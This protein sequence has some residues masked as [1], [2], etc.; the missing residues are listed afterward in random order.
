MICIDT[1]IN[2]AEVMASLGLWIGADGSRRL[3]VGFDIQEF[4]L[5]SGN[6]HVYP[7]VAEQIGLYMRSL[8]KIRNFRTEVSC[9]LCSPSVRISH[10]QYS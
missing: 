2:L 1:S 9:S 7:P 6:G 3:A 10:V 5:L 4:S 8:H